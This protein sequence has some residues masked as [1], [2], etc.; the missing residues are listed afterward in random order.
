MA[1]LESPPV[2]T[3]ADRRD[4]SGITPLPADLDAR[5]LLSRGQGVFLGVLM[6]AVLAVAVARAAGAGPSPLWWAG[7]AVAFVTA[8]YVLVI[9]FKLLLVFR[10]GS[11][12]VL[13]FD[14]ADYRGI[15]DHELPVYT[16]LVPL[17]REGKVLDGLIK[18]LAGLDYPAER[19][20][21]LLLIEEDDHQTRTALG[22]MALDPQFE[23]VLIPPG[24][25]RTKAKACDVG[26]QRARGELC[27]VY[28]A[29]DRPEPGQ[30]RKAVAAFRSLPPWVVCVQAE[31]QY[32]NPDR[33]LLTQCFAA[34]YAVNF[35]LFL[36]G[37]DRFRLAIPL[38][39]SSSH[40]RA[41]ALRRLGAWDPHNVAE[42]ADLGVR[43]ARRGW[44]VRMMAS[45]TEEEPASRLASWL[46]HR[47]RWTKGYYQ[48]WLV[49]TRSPY[50]LWRDLG[51]VR[52]IGLQMTLALS[53]FTTLVNPVFWALTVAYL[54][55][56]PGRVPQVFPLPELFAAAAAMLLGNLLMVYSLM[57]GCMEHGLF[58][59]VRTMLLVPAYWAL[60]SVA[61]YKALFQLLHPRRRH[62]WEPTELSPDTEHAPPPKVAWSLG[63]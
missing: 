36:R 27:V 21:V 45:V 40:F 8:I 59:A 34:E 30:L 15:P 20:Q 51:P 9:V 49:H 41:E 32:K 4:T 18:D 6:V 52:F 38:G 57:I 50:R 60:M 16:V 5:R 2:H 31:L 3:R 29:A 33:N 47:S 63:N 7:A 56:G 17:Y 14:E 13:R 26:L 48:T 28:G 62:Y 23:V 12:H 42:G 58:R 39:G 44:S 10:G 25:P 24:Q 37:L 35:S 1:Q 53:S 19:V 43:I 55:S 61:A 46:R 11:A 54:V 22:A